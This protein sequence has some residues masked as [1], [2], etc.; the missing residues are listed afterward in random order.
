[1]YFTKNYK[2]NFYKEQPEQKVQIT[3]H[4]AW[5]VLNANNKNCKK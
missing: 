1:M 5:N 3:S 4:A 2:N